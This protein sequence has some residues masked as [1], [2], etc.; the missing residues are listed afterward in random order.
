MK[1]WFAMVIAS[2]LILQISPMTLALEYGTDINPADK[3]YVQAFGD[4]PKSH[5]AFEYIADLVERGVINGY[6]DGKFYPSSTVTRVQFAKIMVLAAGLVAQPVTATGFTD[7][8]ANSWG[9]PYVVCAKPYMT[10]YQTP[11]GKVAFRPNNAALREDIAVA[12]VKLKGYDTSLAD[13][14]ALQV[15]FSDYDSISAAA[16][17][18]IAV[19]VERGII[20][21][22]SDGTFRGQNIV[23]RAEAA[24]ILWR[25]FQVGSD[26][27]VVDGGTA[28]KV[29]T[30]PP[31][32]NDVENQEKPPQ[33]QVPASKYKVQTL[34]A[35]PNNADD[36]VF[37][38]SGDLYYLKDN[39]LVQQSNDKKT[40]LFDGN[41]DYCEEKT[42]G[43]MV[44]WLKEGPEENY[45]S[46]IAD[47]IEQFYDKNEILYFEELT[48]LQLGY[49][50][51]NDTVYVLTSTNRCKLGAELFYSHGVYKAS[52]MSHPVLSVPYHNSDSSYGFDPS[53][54]CTNNAVFYGVSRGES[55]S[56]GFARKYLKVGSTSGKGYVWTEGKYKEQY[57][58]L[59]GDLYK[60]GSRKLSKLDLV[61]NSWKSINMADETMSRAT[62]L[63]TFENQIHFAADKGL[64]TLLPAGT[65]RWKSS[66]VLM[67]S[68][69]EITDGV[70]MGRMDKLLM[71]DSGN[72]IFSDEDQGLLR[73]IAV[74]G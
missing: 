11:D 61:S 66:S 33:E 30:T 67:W 43:D 13:V 28:E 34:A 40:V 5:W 50:Q 9:A 37:T 47:H 44:Q 19:A 7:V 35:L 1:K 14:G 26:N 42:V 27:K 38:E 48:L 64:Y 20:S 3:N 46:G 55:Y 52:D 70:P 32:N 24:A 41:V 23:A 4:V 65:N 60:F 51:Q 62:A 39:Q 29:T 49:D 10:S 72:I 57:I 31:K 17:P 2:M 15:M 45:W 53:L 25:A 21:G 73:K 18:Y 56:I 71:D 74:E 69:L 36:Y 8:A 22:Y 68:G 63:C 12:V 58:Q 16:R 6:A 54:V 59:D